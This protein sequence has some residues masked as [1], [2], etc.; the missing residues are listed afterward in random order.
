M[1]M[2]PW[3]EALVELV[4]NAMEAHSALGTL[5]CRY[6]HEDDLWEIVLYPT[7]VALRGGPDDETVVSP[8][9]SLDLK[10]LLETFE[11]VDAV[12]WT[13]QPF[14]PDD[15]DNP[16]IAIESR[17]QGQA[18]YLQILSEAPPDEPPGLTVDVP[19]AI[20]GELH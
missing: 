12:N 14:G 16:S 3:L 15:S 4:A 11:E 7:P 10:Q 5:G 18:V 13:T 2:P 17:F 1:I 20:P 6:C 8:G 19:S 9:F